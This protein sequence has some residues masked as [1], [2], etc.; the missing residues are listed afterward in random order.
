MKI[1]INEI[2]GMEIGLNTVMSMG[3]PPKTAYW[4]KRL[5][6]KVVSEM[7]AFEN[8]RKA[9]VIKYAKKDKNGKP[10]LKKVK[11]DEP[12]EYDVSKEDMVKVRAEFNE[13]MQKEFDIPFEPIKL[14]AFGD[15]RIKPD[16]LYQLGKLVKE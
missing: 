6:D 3:L 9:L 12:A 5:M 15:V 14:E 4:F 11:K 2:K 13:L 8:K 7:N 10:M 1:T 16:T